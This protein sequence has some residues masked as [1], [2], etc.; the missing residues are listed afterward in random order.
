[1]E[2]KT[3]VIYSDESGVFDHRFQAIALISSQQIVL[4]ELRSKLKGFL[5]EHKIDEIKFSETRTHRPKLDTARDFIRHSVKE[6][7]S[8]LKIRIDVLIW[9]TQDSRHAIQGRDDIA[10]LEFMYYK[11]LTHTARQ[12]NQAEWNFYP[13]KNSQVHWNEIAN[14]L[15]KTQ[16]AR[17]QSNLLLLLENG[18][19]TQPLRFKTIDPLDSLYEPLIQLADLFAGMARFT[20]E[21]GKQCIQWL[22]YCRNKNQLLLPYLLN[23]KDTIDETI[24][25]KQNRFQLVGEFNNLCKRHRMGVS[26][27]QRR[28]LWTPDPTKPINFWNYEPQHEYDKAPKRKS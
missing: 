21:E 18:Y 14:Y 22:D 15:N 9:D 13:D 17:Y 20:R 16:L 26:L 2:S 8:Q 28:C 12:W 19:G 27:R 25:T 24:I 1:M 3:F 23:G 4:S 6:F 11:V 7:A 5:D 10:N